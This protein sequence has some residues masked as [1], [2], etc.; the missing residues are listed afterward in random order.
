MSIA[1]TSQGTVESVFPS[2]KY[3]EYLKNVGCNTEENLT[4]S[5]IKNIFKQAFD[6]FKKNK[7]SLSSF[8]LLGEYLFYKIK[9][10]SSKFAS[11]LLDCS[12]LNYYLQIQENDSDEFKSVF[13]RIENYFIKPE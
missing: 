5:I 4:D 9:E 13:K 3:N 8:C 10:Q 1:Y 7:L 2:D 6:E 11:A 12:E